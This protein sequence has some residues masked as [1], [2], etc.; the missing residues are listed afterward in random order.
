M[1]ACFRLESNNEDEDL[2]CD[3]NISMCGLEYEEPLL[4]KEEQA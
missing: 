2:E 4:K 1:F 3:D